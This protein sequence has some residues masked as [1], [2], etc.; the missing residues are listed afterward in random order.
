MG[1]ARGRHPRLYPLLSRPSI[2]AFVQPRYDL[3]NEYNR[4]ALR[5]GGEV[6]KISL[7]CLIAKQAFIGRLLSNLR[8]W[9]PYGFP[10]RNL[11]I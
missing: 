4:S 1:T 11:G 6:D 9:W 5:L 3:T 10:L 2:A 8:F 7:V